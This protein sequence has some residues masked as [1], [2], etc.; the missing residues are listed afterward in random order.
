MKKGDLFKKVPYLA[1]LYINYHSI[2][3]SCYYLLLLHEIW[4]KTKTFIPILRHHY[5]I[6]KNST[7]NVL[8]KLRVKMNLKKSIFKN[9]RVI[10]FTTELKLKILILVI[11]YWIKSHMKIFWFMT[12]YKKTFVGAKPL[13]ISFDKIDG[14]FTVFDGNR[15]FVLFDSENYDAI[16]NRTRYLLS[17]KSGFIYLIVLNYPRVKIDSYDSL[18]LEKTFWIMLW[19]SLSQFLIKIKITT[20]ITYS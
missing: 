14:I 4:S 2:I 18:L 11:F 6:T 1:Y 17:V 15:Y 13:R 9:V 5:Q 7:N 10:I 3:D 8:Q 16:Y 19:Y 20:I 12:F